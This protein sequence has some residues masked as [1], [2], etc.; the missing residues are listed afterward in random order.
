MLLYCYILF[1]YIYLYLVSS[2]GDCSIKVGENNPGRMVEESE[3]F[4]DQAKEK[5]LGTNALDFL[6]IR[7]EKFTYK[8]NPIKYED[9]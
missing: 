6:G 8:L 5:I 9:S 4:A 2:S 3:E 1:A 7:K